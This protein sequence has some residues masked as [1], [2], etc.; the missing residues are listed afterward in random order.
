MTGTAPGPQSRAL[1]AT[2]LSPSLLTAFPTESLASDLSRY[3]SDQGVAPPDTQLAAGPT[4]LVSAV[5]SA[6]W[7][8]TKNGVVRGSVDL[9]TFFP[10][11]TGYTFTDPR[12]VYDAPT[13]RW[14]V[15]GLA[16]DS[17]N[18]SQ[19]YVATSQTSDPTGLYSVYVVSSEAGVVQDQ[20]KVGLD[21]SVAVLS[22]NDY[23]GGVTF[24]GQETKVMEKA[25][26][27]SGAATARTTSFGPDTTR[28]GIVP[29]Q[30]LS[31]T[32]TEYLV[33]NDSCGTNTT[34]GCTTSTSALGRVAITG[35]P[36]ASNVAWTEA[37]PAIT[38]TTTPP[39]A[40]QP[41]HAATVETNDDRFLTAISDGTT[42][43]LSG[44]DGCVPTGDSVARPCARLIEVTVGAMATV[45]LDSVLAY[46]GADLYF[47][48]LAPDVSGNVFVSAT[49]SSTTTY[50]AA[51]G[52]TLASGASS[53]SKVVFQSGSGANT[54]GRW[55][56]YSGI[57]VDP[58]NPTDIWMGAEYA[59]SSTANWGTAVGEMTLLPHLSIG[60]PS[61][62][63]VGSPITA[64]VTARDGSGSTN[65]AYTGTVH[66]TSS[67]VT[68]TLPANYTFQVADAGVHQF[69]VTLRTTG[70]ETVTATDIATSTVTGTSGAIAVTTAPP[71]PPF[72][73]QGVGAPQVALTPDGSTQLVFWKSTTTN[74]LA[75]AWYTGQWNGP[76]GFPQL[77]TLSS[78]PGVAV[79]KDGST[80]LV[81]WQGPS[82]HLMEAWYTG[83]WNGPLDI[84]STYLGGHGIL[85]SAPS[86][87]TTKD[88]TQLVFWRGTDGH[89]AEA[90]YSNGWH[91][92]VDFTTLGSLASAPS[93]TITPDG[94]TQL[95]FF[96][97]TDGRLVEDWFTGVWN[98]P[99]EFGAISSPPSVAVT[100][101]GTAQLVFYK[102]AAG[103]LLEAW[104]TGSWNGPVDFT[105]NAFGGN[106][107]LTSSPSATV[108]VDGSTQLVFWQG[109]G[110]TLWE[111][112]YANGWHGPVDWSAG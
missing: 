46:S 50:P 42:I 54:N 25:D 51:T 103:H 101:D 53:F 40:D 106:G 59:P 96:Q 6:M 80:Q 58:S 63:T 12:V 90:W 49:Y 28:F 11:P 71:P 76:V 73:P 110:N 20:P 107:L 52:L 84:T 4:D 68:A 88:G 7:V 77:G 9:N 15:S 94:S 79:S 8:W 67:D 29:V 55:G 61:S 5:N 2:T 69:A 14:F 13:S 62:A 39:A 70:A 64:T 21:S 95:V 99:T 36:A 16:F 81:F 93:S 26:L 60:T 85:A 43:Y 32:S 108:T 1:T 82:G 104:Y 33:Y 91:G 34:G 102:S 30:S 100:P 19:V 75:E 57:A 98:G 65:T 18:D 41:G 27:L 66:F 109:A 97:G 37:D 56:D 92:P 17:S 31:S 87:T 105:V 111:G 112:W 47:P 83:T 22:W 23:T 10:L 89:L 48:A 38:A 35:T 3:G 72:S 44:N 74:Q 24:S 78:T 45:T 86:V